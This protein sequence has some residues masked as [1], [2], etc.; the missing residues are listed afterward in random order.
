M[1]SQ[2]GWLVVAFFRKCRAT[3]LIFEL[4]WPCQAKVKKSQGTILISLLV[5]LLCLDIAVSHSF[6]GG[7]CGG[8]GRSYLPNELWNLDTTWQLKY[9]N[10]RHISCLLGFFLSIIAIYYLL[11]FRPDPLNLLWAGYIL[12]FYV[13]FESDVSGNVPFILNNNSN[14]ISS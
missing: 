10:F 8:D 3:K 14:K 12:L 7:P 11:L 13:H 1:G 2:T 6:L 9:P 5:F 4:I